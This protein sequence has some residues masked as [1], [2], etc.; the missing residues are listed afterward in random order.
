MAGSS[1]KQRFLIFRL[2]SDHFSSRQ[3]NFKRDD[4]HLFF[5]WCVPARLA[6]E[7]WYPRHLPARCSGMEW[8]IMI[9]GDRRVVVCG[10]NA[11]QP[12]PSGWKRIKVNCRSFNVSSL[13][14]TRNWFRNSREF[15]DLTLNTGSRGQLDDRGWRHARTLPKSLPSSARVTALEFISLCARYLRP[16]FPSD[17]QES[18]YWER[19]K[20]R[21]K[22]QN[23]AHD[24]FEKA[25]NGIK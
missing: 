2:M 15:V 8:E 10:D 1:R 20:N 19:K 12:R 16:S 25:F 14:S 21:F 5:W 4:N 7:T 11:R 17:W 23:P 6:V 3:N 24:H 18:K 9:N 13:P 22:E